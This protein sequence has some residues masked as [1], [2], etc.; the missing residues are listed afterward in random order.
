M[1][2]ITEFLSI[3]GGYWT[4][5]MN[6]KF[7]RMLLGNLTA[8]SY[9]QMM[10]HG[11]TFFSKVVRRV[12]SNNFQVLQKDIRKLLKDLRTADEW[13][14]KEIH[15]SIRAKFCE[16]EQTDGGVLDVFMKRVG[17][18]LKPVF[19]MLYAMDLSV[20]DVSSPFS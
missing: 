14:A 2:S 9:N 16:K 20:S 15:A 1:S 8:N 7:F 10:Q 12:G 17:I 6:R 11:I 3:H 4:K 13:T 5:Q 18:I 19:E